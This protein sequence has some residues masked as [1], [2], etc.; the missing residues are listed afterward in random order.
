MLGNVQNFV[1]NCPICQTKKSDYT[2]AKGKLQST[3]IPETKWSEISIDFVTDLPTS[4]NNKDIIL[5]KIDKTTRMV[6]LAP[7]RK[8]ITATGTIQLL[9]KTVIRYHGI[10]WVIYSDRGAQFIADSWQELWRLTGTK[11]GYS[12]AYH[13]QT[14]GVVEQMNAVV[15]QTLRCLIHGSHNIKN[16]GILLHTVE[17]VINLLPN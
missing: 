10:P 5:V 14:Q 17:M 9:W 8:T 15:S 6:H 2:L 16:W 12:T 13:P 4:S 11:L 3:Q 1:E 7:C